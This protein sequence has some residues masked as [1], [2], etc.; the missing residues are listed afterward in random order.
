MKMRSRLILAVFLF[1]VLNHLVDWGPFETFVTFGQA[2]ISQSFVMTI[3]T[4]PPTVAVGQNFSTSTA[5]GASTSSTG[6]SV[7]AGS[8]RICVTFFSNANTETPCSTD[9]AA[10]S[11]ITTTGTTSTVT[12]FPPIPTGGFGSIVGWRMYVGA[13]GGASGAE[14]LQTITSS[15]CTLSTSSTASCSLNSPATFTSSANFSGG[16]GGPATPG[17]LLTYPT[18]NAANL[19]LFENGQF[20]SQIISWTLTGTAPSACTFQL[21]T[22]ATIPALANVGQAITCTATGSYALPSVARPTY[23]APNITAFTAGDTTT[24]MSFT[25]TALPY[26]LVNFWGPVAPTSACTAY[27]GFF[28]AASTTTSTIYTCVAGTWT[29]VTLP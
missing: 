27:T 8:Y 23:V 19:A 22:G 18:S 1:L 29:A 12:I 15:I 24:V 2:S 9:T 16:G 14:T 10:T 4:A 7:A 13:N 20:P 17:T 5:T 3:A 11:V 26:P 6:G 21:Q 25:M 28:T